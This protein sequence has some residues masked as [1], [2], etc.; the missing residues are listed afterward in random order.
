MISRFPNNIYLLFCS[1]HIRRGGQKRIVFIGV[2]SCLLKM[3]G[4]NHLKGN[5]KLVSLDINECSVGSLGILE[6]IEIECLN[7]W[8]S[9]MLM[10]VICMYILL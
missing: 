5:L 3:W 6:E 1:D 8:N 7:V 2:P 10:F 4:Q 9:F